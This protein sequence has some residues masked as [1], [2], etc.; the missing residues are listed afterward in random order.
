MLFAK[1][2]PFRVALN[3]VTFGARDTDVATVNGMG[4][5]AWIDD[6][7]A[8]PA[9]DNSALTA[10]LNAQIM[11]IEYAAANTAQ[12]SW[13][14]VNEDRGLNYVNASTPT[15]WNI[16]R[17]A[18]VSIS[19]NERTRIRQELAAVTW[20]RNAHSRY[21][22][23][24]FMAD[25][26]HNHF[27]IGKN[28]N[29]LATALLPVYDRV[30]IRPHVFG[31]FRAMLEANATSSSMMLYLDNWVSTATTPNE[32]YAREIME[33]HTLGEDSYYG[34]ASP[35]S[36]PTGHFG[37]AVGFT[38]QD[39]IQASR[40]LSGWTIQGGQRFGKTILPN[41]GEFTFN[42]AQ[43]NT[44]AGTLLGL[45]VQSAVADN[46]NQ[47]RLLLNMLAY[48]PATA[49]F[50]VRKLARRM[51][52]DFAP[53]AVIDR[54]V[55]A[56]LAFQTAPDQIARVLRAMLVTGNEIREEPATKARR[57]YE[58]LIALARTTD[59]VLNA[60]TLMTSLLDPL[61]DHLFAWQAPNGRPDIN[62]YWLATGATVATWNLLQQFSYIPQVKTSFIAQTPTDVVTSATGVVEYWVG[63][64]V[65]ATL[66]TPAMNALVLDQAGTLGVPNVSRFASQINLENAYRRLVGL[67]A[68]SEE[69]TLR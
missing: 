53:Q 52:G 40:V 69:F 46:M 39:I 45:N 29:E 32:N 66:S 4:W 22:L 60:S 13:N 38:D 12:G 51:F 63:R 3:R 20:I 8:A 14:A 34:T 1:P 7:L 50:I 43:H 68:T 35:S 17:N 64:M 26:W 61:N 6:Q 36:V 5:A 65:G 11:H 31:N 21:Q 24:E 44:Q 10:H 67:I 48:H 30:A 57:P 62:E 16:A 23:R 33:L 58:R 27:N 42:P 2:D 49:N 25:F 56:W 19:F 18:G 41:T 9:G 28:E 54:G 55:G 47:G 37:Y 15:L 59:M